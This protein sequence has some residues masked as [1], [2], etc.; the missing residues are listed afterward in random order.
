[1][2]IPAYVGLTNMPYGNVGKMRSYGADGNVSFRHELNKDMSF[3]VRG[4]YT[5]SKN[6]VENW[7]EANPRYPYQERSGYPHDALRGYQSLGL[8]KDQHDI[9]TSPTQTFG[10]VM[11]GDIKYRDVNGDGKIDADDQVP[12]SYNSTPI[13]MYGFGGEFRYKAFTVGVLFQGTGKTD[14]FYSGQNVQIANVWQNN[15]PGYI[16]FYN[17]LLGNILTIVN[18]PS[19]RWIPKDYAIANG[20][21]PALAENPNARFPRLSY[22]NNANNSQLSTFWKGDARYL[23]LQ[24]I[25]LNYNLKAAFLRKT[26]IASIDIQLV[27]TNLYTWDKVKEFDPE[28]AHKGGRVYPIPTTYAMQLYIN[29]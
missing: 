10:A 4:N 23:R 3:T 21:D 19:N 28:Q 22:G 20:I 7:E 9:D 24:E 5:F 17:G 2:E 25:T 11:P 14:F 29:F 26:G 18:D 6:N 13:L 1:V 8:F 16:P 15:G 12:L 27:G